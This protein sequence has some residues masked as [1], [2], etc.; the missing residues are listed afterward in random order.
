MCE[1]ERRGYYRPDQQQ[2]TQEAYLKGV[3]EQG[4]QHLLG[5]L[6]QGKSEHLQ[7]YLAFASRFHRYSPT[8]Q[9]LIYLQKP[10][11]TRVA[12]Y[13]TWQKLGYQVGKGEKGI[14]IQAPRPYARVDK[15]TGEE[16]HGVRF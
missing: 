5:E 6:E 3:V 10:E 7:R 11:A 8:N 2:P 1:R 13:K 16:E 4:A 12:G 14:R 15:E 9:L